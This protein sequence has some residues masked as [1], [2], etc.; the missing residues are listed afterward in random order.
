M[1]NVTADIDGNIVHIGRFATDAAWVKDQVTIE[2]MVLADSSFKA[3]PVVEPPTVEP[4][5]AVLERT[6]AAPL[7]PEIGAI[8]LRLI[9]SSSILSSR[10]SRSRASRSRNKKDSRCG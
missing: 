2:Q 6:F 10:S 9:S 7:M 5:G 1:H 4:L 8:D 3:A